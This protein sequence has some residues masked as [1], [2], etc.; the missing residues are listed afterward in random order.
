MFETSR[1]HP[2]WSQ[3]IGISSIARGCIYK[4]KFTNGIHGLDSTMLVL[5]KNIHFLNSI[6]LFVNALNLIYYSLLLSMYM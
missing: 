5:N 6:P 4:T 2:L 3:S 1:S